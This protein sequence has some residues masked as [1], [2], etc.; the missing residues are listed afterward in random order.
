[1]KLVPTLHGVVIQ[2]SAISRFVNDWIRHKENMFPVINELNDT[3]VLAS[4]HHELLHMSMSQTED[5]V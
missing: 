5:P 2:I 3:N 1:M 4:L